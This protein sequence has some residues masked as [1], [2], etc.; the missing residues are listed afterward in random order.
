[1][2]KKLVPC[3]AIAIFLGIEMSYAQKNESSDYNLVKA[4]E[5]TQQGDLT[6]AMKYIDKQITEYPK[7]SG[8]YFLKA[9]F[10]RREKNYGNALININKALKFWKKGEKYPK[11]K[12]ILYW[13]RATI[14]RDMEMYDKALSDFELAYKFVVKEDEDLIHDLLFQ[15]AQLHYDLE[16]YK[17]ADADYRLM[18]KHNEADQPAMAGLMRNMLIRK[19]YQGVIDMANTCE[20]Y[21][22]SYDEI[23]RFRMQAYDQLGE[24]DKAIDDALLYFLCTEDF[25]EELIKPILKKRLEYVLAKVNGMINK[26]GDNRKWKVLRICI[27][28]WRNDYASAINGYNDVENEYGGHPSLNYRR[29]LC[30]HEIGDNERAIADITKCIEM[31]NGENYQALS[32]RGYFYQTAGQ[33]ENAIADFSKLIEI[34][35]TYPYGYYMRGHCYELMGDDKKAIENYNA[36]IE[37]DKE[38]P[39]MLLQRGKLL[40]KQGNVMKAK[41]DFEEIIKQDTAVRAAS[42]RHYA[43]HF[44]SRDQ[45]ALEWMEKIIAL[46]PEDEGE[47]YDKVCLLSLMGKTK[48]AI[49]AL[50]I[51]LEKGYRSFSHIE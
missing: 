5:L 30:Y 23:Y 37:I 45:E 26:E 38:V 22:N 41:A 36:S 48:E 18:L 43:L 17:S 50:R 27:H 35:P 33:Y 13:W 29:S 31:E 3:I 12:C 28:E 1:M 9:T 46:D 49:A 19:E 14:Y 39:Y 42:V 7:S 8:G 4:E 40:V 47:H 51:S 24:T 32:M 16:D 11:Y 44:L 34:A 2:I 6:E 25:Q 21:D 20:K 15:R 10:F